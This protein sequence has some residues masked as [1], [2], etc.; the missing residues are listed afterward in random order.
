MSPRASPAC[1]SSDTDLVPKVQMPGIKIR[2]THNRDTP[3][4][5]SSHIAAFA[6]AAS[7][8]LRLCAAFSSS[9]RLRSFSRTALS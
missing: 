6:L 9:L 8:S 1:K 3:G 5:Q 4:R 7:S 2:T